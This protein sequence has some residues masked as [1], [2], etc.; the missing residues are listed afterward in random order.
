MKIIRQI[1]IGFAAISATLALALYA[2]LS[3][4]GDRA[5]VDAIPAIIVIAVGALTGFFLLLLSSVMLPLS[6]VTYAV[7]SLAKG[8]FRKRIYHGKISKSAVR[9][10]DELSRTLMMLEVMRRKL[11]EVKK[12]FG[13]SMERKAIELQR[14]NDELMEKEDVLKKANAQLRGQAEEFKRMN[15][16]FS[17]KNDELSDVNEQLQLLDRMKDDFITVAAEE[18]CTPIVP[19]LDTVERSERGAMDEQEAW[20]TIMSEA[21]RLGRV[22][23]SILDVGKIESGNFTYDMKPLGVKRLIEEVRPLPGLGEGIK[24]NLDLD[25]GGD[26]M[27]IGDLKRLRQALENIVDT[28]RH[29]K[30]AIVTI[31]TRANHETGLLEIRITDNGPGIPPDVLPVL[32]DKYVTGTRDKERRRGLGLYIT[33]T[34]IEAHGGTISAENYVGTNSRGVT[35]TLSLPMQVQRVRSELAPMES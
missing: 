21:K 29:V 28:V 31:R 27:I 18:L 26:V 22:A 24:V 23:N 35:F 25:P 5:F 2:L 34:I 33:K 3:F 15:Q 16:E 12:D 11:L 19:I 30:D 14:I 9:N 1:T 8:K 32:F 7:R 13:D 10:A 6:E 4:T 20:N 17:S